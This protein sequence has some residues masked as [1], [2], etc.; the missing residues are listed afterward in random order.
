M[1]YKKMYLCL[2]NSITE[3]L[4]ELQKYEVVSEEVLSVENILK[5]A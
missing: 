1:D 2:F 5:K 4:D 3:A